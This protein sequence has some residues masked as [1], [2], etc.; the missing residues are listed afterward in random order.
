MVG[1]IAALACRTPPHIPHDP[2]QQCGIDVRL[3]ISGRSFVALRCRRLRR[4]LAALQVA[5][6]QAEGP[7]VRLPALTLLLRHL[8]SQAG[9]HQVGHLRVGRGRGGM[10][11]V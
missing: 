4:R 6:R 9:S 8:S 7:T 2:H 1:L 3:G 10:W 5:A 11:E